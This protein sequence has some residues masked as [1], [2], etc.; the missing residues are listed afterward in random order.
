MSK[1]TPNWQHHSRKDQK[2]SLRPV[3]I[4]MPDVELRHLKNSYQT[5]TKDVL[6]KII[7]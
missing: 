3:A 5:V 6:Y 4:E 7:R 2:R 1:I